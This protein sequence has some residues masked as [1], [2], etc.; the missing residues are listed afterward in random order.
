[1]PS[2]SNLSKPEMQKMA[3][4]GIGAA[5]FV[6]VLIQF[7]TVPS[8]RRAA[9]LKKDIIKLKESTKKSQVLIANAPQMQSRLVVLQQKLKNYQTAL[10][11]RSDMPNILQSISGMAAESR[12][13]LLKIE[14]LRSE[15][16][17]APAAKPSTAKQ[18]GKQDLTKAAQPIYMEIPIQIE[19]K[20]GYHALGEFINRIET[21]ANVMSVA[22]ID[23]ERDPDDMFNHDARLLIIAYV[24]REETPAK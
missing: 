24:L 10:P 9:E 20:C 7:V 13:K 4:I 6:F 17:E 19:S 3:A 14:P 22:D 11:T 2:S 8:V 16:Q 21:A 23:I 5:V 12:V 18:Q 15:K 1:M